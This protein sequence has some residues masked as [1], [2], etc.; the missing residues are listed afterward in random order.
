MPG[1]TANYEILRGPSADHRRLRAVHAR[2]TSRN[3]PYGPEI[4]PAQPR[5][6]AFSPDRFSFRK[7]ASRPLPP[8]AP[9]P[10]RKELF[11]TTSCPNTFRP[12][13]PD[14]PG[15]IAGLATYFV[16]LADIY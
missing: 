7:H 12:K 11:A 10:S 13:I 1:I 2:A 15:I 4:Q 3:L 16:P 5:V 14:Q 6:A 8:R 9:L